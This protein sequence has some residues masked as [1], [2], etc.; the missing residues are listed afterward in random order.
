MILKIGLQ[1]LLSSCNGIITAHDTT[2]N[3]KT[4]HG[5]IV[6]KFKVKVKTARKSHVKKNIEALESLKKTVVK[7]VKKSSPKNRK[8]IK[9]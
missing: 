3:Y 6:R 4:F 9:Q 8:D 2:V 5:F 7:P 1:G